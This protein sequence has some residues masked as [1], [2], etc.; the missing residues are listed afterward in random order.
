[1]IFKR[2]TKTRNYFFPKKMSG[3]KKAAI[4]ALALGATGLGLWIYSINSDFEK[5]FGNHQSIQ[6][7]DYSSQI[8]SSL[9]GLN[10]PQ[11]YDALTSH[12][13]EKTTSHSLEQKVALAKPTPTYTPIPE[14][15]TTPKT[16][17]TLK[18]IILKTANKSLT[19]P[20]IPPVVLPTPKP[21]V[22]PTPTPMATPI[23]TYTPTPRATPTPSLT[24]IPT[25]T[26]T[27]I[28][29]KE[30]TNGP[31]IYTVALANIAAVKELA[32]R[33]NERVKETFSYLG[34]KLKE[35]EDNRYNINRKDIRLSTETTNSVIVGE[36]N[37]VMGTP[38]FY[39]SIGENGVSVNGK[40]VE[41]GLEF[42]AREY[43]EN[44][45]IIRNGKDIDFDSPRKLVYVP[46]SK[47]EKGIWHVD[48]D[49][50][51][52]EHDIYTARPITDK[53]VK[54]FIVIPKHEND[55][56]TDKDAKPKEKSF[57]LFAN[58]TRI[59]IPEIK[60][61]SGNDYI[62]QHILIPKP[63]KEV[64]QPATGK[65]G[66]RGNVYIPVLQ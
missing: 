10:F 15:T 18:Y 43:D 23:P 47:D 1:M 40:K 57:Y 59:S 61:P 25:P 22:T 28:P 20:S 34:K 37:R 36:P 41:K 26:P 54:D 12:S 9:K 35:T 21:T 3:I 33:G 55:L 14:P 8:P 48:Y 46:I 24:P 30:K 5:H 11:K 39:Q 44:L 31:S 63:A 29:S 45:E 6:R 51:L 16:E 17:P 66:K 27:P 7:I 2:K 38:Y 60:S 49:S 4:G 42:L 32:Q 56:L 58:G 52:E 64:Y 50:Q 62:P 13:Q 65:I 19:S 53:D